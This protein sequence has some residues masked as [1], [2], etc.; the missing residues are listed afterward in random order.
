MSAS[1]KTKSLLPTSTPKKII[2]FS[3]ENVLVSGKAVEH[4][5]LSQSK[6]LVKSVSAFAQKRNIS[7]YVISAHTQK[8]AENKLNES[9]LRSFFSPDHVVGV[10]A[11]YIE[12]M[13]PIDRERYEAKC[14]DDETC[15]DEYF[16]QVALQEIIQKEGVS[17][18]QIVLVG[19]DLWFDGFYTRRYSNVDVFFVEKNLRSRGHPISEKVEGIWQGTLSFSTIKKIAEG[20]MPAP[21]YT[22]LDTWA[23]VT[24]TQ[25]LFGSQGFN[26]IKRVIIQRKKPSPGDD[27][28]KMVQ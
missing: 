13:Q 11:H 4:V 15:T 21:N 18:A 19:H 8:I 27:T 16:R 22:P 5:D 2:V 17:P 20:K 25:E 23:S 3:L 12:S 7:V 26:S 9:G 1:I 28:P 14:K 24:L 6:R 10:H